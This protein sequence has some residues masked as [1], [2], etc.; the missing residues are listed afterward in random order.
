MDGIGDRA[1]FDEVEHRQRAKEVL[2]EAL[3]QAQAE[4]KAN[5][6][7]EEIVDAELEAW[8]AERN[9]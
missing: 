8:R 7:T 5:G 9:A 6:L 3:R 4:A 2:F 1:A